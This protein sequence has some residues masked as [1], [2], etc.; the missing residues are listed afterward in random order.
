MIGH[1]RAVTPTQLRTL[2]KDPSSVR[3]LLRGK[4]TYA[5]GDVKTAALLSIEEMAMQ[6]VLK[7]A[8][9]AAAAG[10][11][12]DSEANSKLRKQIIAKLESAGVTVDSGS[13]EG[14]ALEKS[15]HSL[16]YLLTGTAWETDTILGKVILGGTEIGPDMGYGPARYLEPNEVKKVARAL[17]TVSKK[18]LMSRFNLEA[19]KA[20]KVY[21]CRDEGELQLAQM[22]F[23]Q[24]YNYYEGTAA[25]GDAMLLYLD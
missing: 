1:L 2:K 14:L 18:D 6:R 21:A 23:T 4:L 5:S 19:M 25:R 10:D 20:A 3:E 17:K 12:G 9:Q 16:H 11:A 8:K 24:V 15:W 13:E 7:M 22:Y